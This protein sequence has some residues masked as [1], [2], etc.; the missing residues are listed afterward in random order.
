MN[1]YDCIKGFYE[2]TNTEKKIIGESVFWRS[3]YALKCGNGTP[4]GLAQYAIHGREYVTAK[5]AI[6]HFKRGVTRGSVWIVPLVNPDGALLSEVGLSTAP[7]ERREYLLALNGGVDFSLWKANGRG[8]DLNVNFAARWGKGVKNVFYPSSENYVGESPFSEPESLALKE[9]TKKIRPDY[10]VSFHTKG[11]EIYWCFHQPKSRRERDRLLAEAVSKATG[12][13]LK[14]AKGSAGGYKDWCVQS[15]KI[16]AFTVEVGK[17]EYTHPLGDEA[18]KD[19]VEKNADV[20]DVLAK[21]Y[22]I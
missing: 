4:V 8:V 21:A 19:I 3:V 18:L 11:E 22:R 2:R 13:P 20:L 17:D 12:Y 5:L 6:E 14:D 9:F 7:K 10:T 1:I 15:L 16:P